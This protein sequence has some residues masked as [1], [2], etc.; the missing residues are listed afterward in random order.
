MSCNH[1]RKGSTGAERV[2]DST[3]PR[4]GC[5]P[6]VPGID[7]RPQPHQRGA[8]GGGVPEVQRHGHERNEESG[9]TRQV[10]MRSIRI[11]SE[12]TTARRPSS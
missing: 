11:D 7:L 6:R 4:R 1:P 12:A 8:H 5:V 10:G 3:R 9:V 2:E